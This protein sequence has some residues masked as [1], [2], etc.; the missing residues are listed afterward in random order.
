[1]EKAAETGSA[2]QKFVEKIEGKGQL[3]HNNSTKR[4][5]GTKFLL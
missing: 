5:A 2:A 1:M 4:E 3:F